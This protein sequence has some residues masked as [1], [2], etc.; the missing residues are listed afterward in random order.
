MSTATA[1][2][3]KNRIVAF[4]VE[5]KEELFLI[6]SW[7]LPAFDALKTQVKAGTASAADLLAYAREQWASQLTHHNPSQTAYDRGYVDDV[8]VID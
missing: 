2:R 5:G 4:L 3:P 7:L 8:I 1:D 6:W